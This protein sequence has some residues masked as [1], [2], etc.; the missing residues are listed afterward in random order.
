MVLLQDA[1]YIS[2]TSSQATP[3]QM[4]VETRP[5]RL[6]MF[7]II[8]V[9]CPPSH[10][11]LSTV[12][13]SVRASRRGVQEGWRCESRHRLLCAAEP[14]GPSRAPCRDARVPTGR[15][16]FFNELLLLLLLLLSAAI[17]VLVVNSCVCTRRAGASP[18]RGLAVQV[19]QS[20]ADHW[21]NPRCHRAVPQGEQGHGE[22]NAA[23]Q[24]GSGNHQGKGCSSASLF[25]LVQCPVVPC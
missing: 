15:P 2:S 20:P 11:T 13:W 22:R 10:P 1:P 18:D 19:R 16:L 25:S 12:G 14:V 21:Q 17:A 4:S 24:D 9:P 23:R 8:T 5:G 3:R 7:C 6:V